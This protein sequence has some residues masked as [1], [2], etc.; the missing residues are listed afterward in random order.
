MITTWHPTQIWILFTR[1]IEPGRHSLFL[2]NLASPRSSRFS[3]RI[4]TTS[5]FLPEMAPPPAMIP[6]PDPSSGSALKALGRKTATA[7]AEEE[8]EL[9]ELRKRNAELERKVKEGRERE[10]R[11]ATD[12]ERV[13]ERL[14]TVEEAEERLCAQLGELEA[15]SVAHARSYHHRIKELHDRLANAQRILDSSSSS[16][17]P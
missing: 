16:I 14:R 2:S 7:T 3:I 11:L 9:E 5:R 1:Y 12:L 4:L 10:E 6:I 17:V 8:E 13:L 15:E